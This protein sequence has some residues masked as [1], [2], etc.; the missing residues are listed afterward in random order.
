MYTI[1][2][3]PVVVVVVSA[4]ILAIGSAPGSVADEYFCV[5]G[6]VVGIAD[7]PSICA[8]NRL[9]DDRDKA[10]TIANAATI[11]VII[12]VMTTAYLCLR[13]NSLVLIPL[14]FFL[15]FALQLLPFL[16]LRILQQFE[17][18][19]FA[20]VIAKTKYLADLVRSSQTGSIQRRERR[21]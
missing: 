21:D 4:E 19:E 3:S 6:V 2:S 10:L 14:H 18:Q 1:C 8:C 17:C 7:C 5:V 11:T 9:I 12:V 15:S 20:V 13:T 16:L